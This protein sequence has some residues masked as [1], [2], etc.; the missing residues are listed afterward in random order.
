MMSKTRLKK[1]LADMSHEQLEQ[2]ILDA[3]DARPEIK[4]YFE[5]FLNPDVDK[6]HDRY[7]AVAVKE[8]GRTRRGQSK[9]RVTHINRAVRTFAGF[10][11]GAQSVVDFM[12]G[13]LLLTGLAD[14]NVRLMPTHERFVTSLTG[15]ILKTGDRCQIA[16]YVME[17]FQALLADSRLRLHFKN[18]VR[19]AL[20]SER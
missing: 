20:E 3:Y 1:E 9:A 10:A 16:E 11:P 18:L 4:E 13:V 5:F 14:M 2:M 15:E 17:K 6:L 19:K 7:Y 8:F 12:F